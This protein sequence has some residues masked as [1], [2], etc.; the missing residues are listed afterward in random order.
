MVAPLIWDFTRLGQFLDGSLHI[1]QYTYKGREDYTDVRGDEV[2][3]LIRNRYQYPPAIDTESVRRRLWSTQFSVTPGTGYLI[4]PEDQ[5][6]MQHLVDACNRHG[7]TMHYSTEDWGMLAKHGWRLDD[8]PGKLY[9]TIQAA[10]VQAYHSGGAGGGENSSG[11]MWGGLGLKALTWRMVG[12]QMGSY[13][14]LV[15]GASKQAVLR[16]IEA[17]KAAVPVRY[18]FLKTKTKEKSGRL[19]TVLNRI[20][21]YTRDSEDYDPWDRWEEAQARISTMP[22][23]PERDEWEAELLITL[24]EAGPIPLEGIDQAPRDQAIQY[25]CEDANATGL[26]R[27]AL[28]Q[29]DEELAISRRVAEKDWVI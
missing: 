24:D 7:Y 6:G 21:R 12:L 17:A 3:D 19:I 28:E 27:V 22:D 1:P 14:Q 5:V 16:W 29:L 2:R 15:T 10:F 20:E 25:A 9:D 18:E 26:L 13:K 11:G 23:G 4:W 8:S